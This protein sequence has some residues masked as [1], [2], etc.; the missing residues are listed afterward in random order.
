[1]L[2]QEPAFAPFVRQYTDLLKTAGKEIV[3]SNRLSEA[4]RARLEEPLVPAPD[5]VDQFVTNANAYVDAVLSGK[6]PI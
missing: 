6:P 4:T 5:F 2:L 1:M 3:V